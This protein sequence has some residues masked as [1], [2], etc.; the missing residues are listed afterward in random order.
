MKVFYKTTVLFKIMEKEIS[1]DR[2]PESVNYL[3]GKVESLEQAFL[4]MKSELKYPNPIDGWMDVDG[5]IDY[6]PDKPA[7][8]TVY[9]WVSERK[10]PHHKGGKKLRFLKSEIDAW[11]SEGKRKSETELEAEATKYLTQK[12]GRTKYDR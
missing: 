8:P 10:I 9:G 6:L 7:K 11:L 1:F 4:Q 5:L 12:G 2:L 3:I